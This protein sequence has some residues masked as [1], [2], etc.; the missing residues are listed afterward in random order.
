MLFRSQVTD[1]LGKSSDDKL[2]TVGD[3]LSGDLSGVEENVYQVQNQSGQDPLNFP[4]KV[5]NRLASLLGVV[6]RSDAKPI[7]SALPIFE[8]LKS[9]LKVETDHLQ[10]ILVTDLPAF[11]TELK[12]LG[13]DPIVIN[14]AVIF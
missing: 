2:K 10:K 9:E 13:L 1:R 7:A 5:N 12:R 11:N 14:R 6:S 4:I 3:H 8:D